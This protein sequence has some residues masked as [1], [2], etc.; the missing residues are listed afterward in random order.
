MAKLET[1]LDMLKLNKVKKGTFMDIFPRDGYYRNQYGDY[2]YEIKPTPKGYK[3]DG[4][5]A[6]S[7]NQYSTIPRMNMY[8]NGEY[9]DARDIQLGQEGLL[10]K[11][12]YVRMHRETEWPTDPSASMIDNMKQGKVN[13][14]EPNGKFDYQEDDNEWLKRIDY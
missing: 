11:P 1:I 7:F 14:V 4:E 12:D 13:V 10:G 6:G 2:P 9:I 3:I 8:G 5:Q